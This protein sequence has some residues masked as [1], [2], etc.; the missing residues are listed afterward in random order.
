MLH[1]RWQLEIITYESVCWRFH[2]EIIW[3]GAKGIISNGV[4]ILLNLGSKKHNPL[5]AFFIVEP[6]DSKFCQETICSTLRHA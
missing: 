6:I 4:H 1:N 3:N 2:N 5:T